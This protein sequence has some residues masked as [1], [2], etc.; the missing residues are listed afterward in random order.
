LRVEKKQHNQPVEQIL[1]NN[2]A[3]GPDIWWK[4]GETQADVDQRQNGKQR[5]HFSRSDL[6]EVWEDQA[7]LSGFISPIFHAI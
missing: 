1:T 7:S 2:G 4:G 6:P 3:I 5:N